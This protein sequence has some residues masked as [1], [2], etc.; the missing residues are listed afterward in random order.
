MREYN[1]SL[2]SKS[3]KGWDIFFFNDHLLFPDRLACFLTF[4]FQ[5]L[6]FVSDMESKVV[7]LT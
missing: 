6:S 1:T 2:C 5:H 4:K 7:N 3:R